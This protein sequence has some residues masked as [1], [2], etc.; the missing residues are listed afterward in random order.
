MRALYREWHQLIVAR[1]APVA[2][3]TV[4]LG[5]GIGTFEQ[6]YPE[7]VATDVEATPWTATVADAERLDFSPGSVANI[8][9]TDVLHHL[10]RPQR[11][12]DEAARVLAP[13]G[14]VVMVEPYCSL[15]SGLAYRFA[16]HEG[17]DLGADPFSGGAQ[18]SARPLDANNALATLIFWRHAARFRRSHP[19]LEVV[20]RHRFATLIYPLSGGFT[21][22]RLVPHAARPA[23]RALERALEP[24][25]RA[26]A[27]R[28]LVV[29][30]R[31]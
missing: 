5:S 1:L 13:G 12:F 23:L 8:V 26:L 31:R 3:P 24:F 2:G 16:H 28:C 22:R 11:F 21:G 27:F 20:E 18:S 6:V 14:R 10:P 29:L 17:A 9:M 25:A 15:V 19:E 7:V 30:E 4:E